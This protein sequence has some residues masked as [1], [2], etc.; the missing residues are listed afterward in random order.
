MIGVVK[1]YFSDRGFGFLAVDGDPEMTFFHVSELQ[2]IGEESVEIGQRFQF[3]LAPN[4]R[5]ARLMAVDLKLLD[6]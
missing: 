4:P 1:R 5:N 2:R 3:S 6:R